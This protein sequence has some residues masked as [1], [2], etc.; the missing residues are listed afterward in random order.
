M[1]TVITML[2]SPPI[3]EHWH[4]PSLFYISGG[5][6]LIWSSAWLVLIDRDPVTQ[7]KRTC[8]LPLSVHE[9]NVIQSHVPLATHRPVTPWRA[10]LS[11]VTVYSLL[12]AH[13][14]STY[15]ASIFSSHSQH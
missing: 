9:L 8:C 11:S 15:L 5:L 7:L 12:F 14:A 4:W 2:L 13:F 6:G 1:G 10:I 3:M